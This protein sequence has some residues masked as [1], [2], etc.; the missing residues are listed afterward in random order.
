MLDSSPS[1]VLL[2]AQ[3]P[4]EAARGDEHV[5][6]VAHAVVAGARRNAEQHGEAGVARH[7]AEAAEARRGESRKHDEA[8]A[9]LVVP[10][11]DE[12]RGHRHQHAAE[13]AAARDDEV[14]GGQPFRRR[15]QPVE[16]PVAEE[17]AEEQPRQEDAE[18]HRQVELEVVV[19]DQPSHGCDPH[20]KHRPQPF[21]PVPA[22][23]VEGEDEARK[24]ERKRR[25]PQRH[26]ATL[27]QV[28]RHREQ[29]HR[30][31]S[32]Q[33]EPQHDVARGERERGALFLHAACGGVPPRHRDAA[34]QARRRP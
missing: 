8:D 17:A 26:K 2:D 31:R 13:R 14:E 10:G 23:A 30:A 21:R 5:A 12:R 25:K 3:H 7:R 4:V 32:R 15:P 34:R 9:E 22:L 27:G 11:E 20:E 18:L 6:L 24:V 29:Q 16:L 28:I 19:D 1:A 33:G